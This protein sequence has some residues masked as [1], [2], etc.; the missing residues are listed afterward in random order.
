MR[1]FARFSLSPRR[2]ASAGQWLRE[3]ILLQRL[4]ATLID[5]LRLAATAEEAW[6][7]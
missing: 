6:R 5:F 7:M 1:L 2:R 4:S 3:S